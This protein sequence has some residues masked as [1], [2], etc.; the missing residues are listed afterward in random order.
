MAD[1]SVET[2][3]AAPP[4]KAAPG[5]P[6]PKKSDARKKA[7]P[8]AKPPAKS[9]EGTA[10]RTE[11][12]VPKAPRRP[13]LTAEVA[14]LLELRRQRRRSQPKFT[15]QA[16]YRYFRIGRDGSWRRPRGLQ[17]KQRRHYGYRSTVVSVG[18]RSPAQTRGLTSVGFRPVVVSTPREIEAL[19]AH[20]DA[21]IIARTV[22][23]RRRLTLEEIARR[24]GLH[25]L[26][27][28]VEERAEE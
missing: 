7:S 22:G 15:R 12:K 14:R 17:S 13:E 10:K 6:T 4:E 1:E 21:A 23:T 9:E 18:F 25:L 26:N 3:E 19:D 24:R 11:A 2:K 27:P 8:A 16:S 28:L 20:H 5:K